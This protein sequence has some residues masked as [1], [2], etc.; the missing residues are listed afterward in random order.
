MIGFSDTCRCSDWF[1]DLSLLLFSKTEPKQDKSFS[2]IFH[3]F[4]PFISCLSVVLWL[5]KGDLPE[6]VHTVCPC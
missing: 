2:S 6:N 4:G 5:D 1:I 3:R